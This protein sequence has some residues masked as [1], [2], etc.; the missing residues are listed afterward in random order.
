MP[1][2]RCGYGNHV[3]ADCFAKKHINGT[4]LYNDAPSKTPSRR[5]FEAVKR[6]EKSKRLE[7]KFTRRVTGRDADADL[8]FNR[9]PPPG[10]MTKKRV[11][12]YR[13]LKYVK[14]KTGEFKVF[15]EDHRPER[16]ER[17]FRL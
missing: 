2:G 3:L 5:R 8:I 17:H 7:Y 6:A 13:G 10:H 9:P 14:D 12:Y 1:C 11:W 4:V 16:I 15:G